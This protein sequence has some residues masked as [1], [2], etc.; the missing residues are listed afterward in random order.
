[1]KVVAVVHVNALRQ[2]VLTVGT[3]VYFSSPRHY[4]SMENHGGMIL[5][6]EDQRTQRNSGLCGERL[7]TNDLTHGTALM[8]VKVKHLQ[9]SD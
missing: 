7:M 9:M 6:I 8:E 3:N 4:M 2:L 5:T 1:M